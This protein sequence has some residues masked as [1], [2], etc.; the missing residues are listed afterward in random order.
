MDNTEYEV[1]A[2]IQIAMLATRPQQLSNIARILEED[3]DME[4]LQK[5]PGI[6]GVWRTEGEELW[7]IAK[8]YHATAENIIELADK[9][10]VV[11]QVR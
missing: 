10:L 3:L 4:A 8:K 2:A 7:D 6:I 5:Q 9:V 1:K 11:K